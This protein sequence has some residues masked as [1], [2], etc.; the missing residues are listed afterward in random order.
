[1]M[2]DRLTNEWTPDL[3]SAFGEY[4]VIGEQGEVIV[5][6]YL[7]DQGAEVYVYPDSYEAQA[8]YKFDLAFKF[9]HWKSFVTVNVKAQKAPAQPKNTFRIKL[10]LLKEAVDVG[11]VHRWWHIDLLTGDMAYYDVVE[12]YGFI[13]R[14]LEVCEDK[15]HL[16][17]P[18]IE[19]YNDLLIPK[20]I[21]VDKFTWIDGDSYN[22]ESK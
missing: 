7:I 9:P 4:G 1:M 5:P 13:T 16:E 15:P 11:T 12:M 19:Y 14:R 22:I 18:F 21:F 3:K 6:K 10:H 17:N 20:Q 8:Q 2:A